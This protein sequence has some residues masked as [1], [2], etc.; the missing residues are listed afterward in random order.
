[1]RTI[2]TFL[3][4]ASIALVSNEGYSQ[5]L[6]S[7]S[8]ASNP[9]TKKQ[10]KWKRSEW[11]VPISLIT[12]GGIIAA[13]KGAN[14]YF[15][16]N[17]EV[18]E[19]RNNHFKNFSTHADN[20]LQYAPAAAV[21]ALRLGGI[22]GKHDIANQTAL[23]IKSELLMTAIVF[24][25]KK[26][27]GEPRPDT[28]AKNSFPSGHTAQAFAAATFLAKEYGHKNI[29]YSIGAYTVATGVAAFRVLNNRHWLSDVIAGAGVGILSTNIVYAT[30]QYKWGKSKK[31]ARNGTL[32]VTPTYGNRT[33]GLYLNY[34]F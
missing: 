26:I 27:V 16:N 13:N 12:T 14:E 31:T 21:F 11:I 17:H 20:Y 7:D 9:A 28:G 22:K 23:F 2:Y 24:P 15:F 33:T 32:S 10:K 4:L 6:P 1:M 29:L 25:T 3:I 8:T 19:E 5:S 18:R 34:K 30:H